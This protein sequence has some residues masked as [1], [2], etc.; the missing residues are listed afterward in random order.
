MHTHVTRRSSMDVLCYNM[1]VIKY[2]QCQQKK[3]KRNTL[4]ASTGSEESQGLAN[5]MHNPSTSE[6]VFT[7]DIAS[8]GFIP[9]FIPSTI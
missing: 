7:F 9:S 3:R 1:F 5:D 4:T 8:C 2:F 6:R